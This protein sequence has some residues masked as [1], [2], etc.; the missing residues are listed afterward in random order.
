VGHALSLAQSRDPYH[1]GAVENLAPDPEAPHACGMAH[2]CEVCLNF[3]PDAASAA[4]ATPLVFG[5]RKVH[6][7]RGHARI[8]ANAKA[9]TFDALRQ[10]Y[11]SGRRSFVPRRTESDAT[12]GRRHPGRRATDLSAR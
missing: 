9:R 6:L 3:R 8:A 12:F 4:D 11:G 5:K 10:L 7:C 1:R 2:V